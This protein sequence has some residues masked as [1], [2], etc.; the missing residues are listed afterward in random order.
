MGENKNPYFNQSGCA[1]PTAYDALKPII[2]EEKELEKKVRNLMTV[3]KLI[4][5]WAG[6]EFIG[7]IQL[8]HKKTGKEFK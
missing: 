2:K 4:V 7:R 6:F 8:K 3:L 5:D 1:D